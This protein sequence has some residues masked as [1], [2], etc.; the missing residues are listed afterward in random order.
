LLLPPL[1]EGLLRALIQFLPW[2]EARV[3][4]AIQRV[5]QGFSEVQLPA[6]LHDRLK[7]FVVIL[8]ELVQ[9]PLLRYGKVSENFPHVLLDQVDG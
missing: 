2:L 8:F 6:V 3:I 7:E 5:L 9:E 1:L 4:R